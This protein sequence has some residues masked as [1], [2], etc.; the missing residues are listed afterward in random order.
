MGKGSSAVRLLLAIWWG[1][2]AGEKLGLFHRFTDRTRIN[3]HDVWGLIGVSQNNL[4]TIRAVNYPGGNQPLL[5]RRDLAAHGPSS[6]RPKDSSLFC[7]RFHPKPTVLIGV[8]VCLSPL[9]P[10]WGQHCAWLRLCP[11]PPA[12]LAAP[13]AQWTWANLSWNRKQ[14]QLHQIIKVLHRHEMEYLDWRKC[15]RL[16]NF[17][18]LQGV[19]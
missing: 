7:A 15:Q 11:P 1:C 12:P 17:T 16:L 18:F 9:L 2:R 4:L 10:P 8:W 19:E 6:L 5:A 3:E 13:G 14:A